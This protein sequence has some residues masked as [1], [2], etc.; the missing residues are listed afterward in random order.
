MQIRGRRV[1]PGEI[2]AVL[3][4]AAG[5]RQAAV[6]LLRDGGR[7]QLVA[8]V[9]LD[10]PD[11]FDPAVLL[12]HARERLPAHM[13]PSAVVALSRLPR[14]PSGK[15]DR[16]ELPRP[17]PSGGAQ[18]AGEGLEADLVAIFTDVLGLDSVGPEHDFF[19]LGGDS[20]LSIQAV[21]RAREVGLWITP[22]DI[23]EHRTAAALARAVAGRRA[24]IDAEQGPIEGELSLMPIHRWFLE[25]DPVGVD[26]FNQTVV[27]EVPA[28]LDPE[29]LR[30]AIGAL[31][32]HHDALRL[33]FG[34]DGGGWRAEHAPVQGD[35]VVFEGLDLGG[36][37]PDRAQALL[38]QAVHR[39]Q[40][41]LDLARGPLT[42]VLW[43]SAG[44]V[45]PGRLVWVVH[46][47]VV[48]GVSW[49]ILL[50]DLVRATLQLEAGEPIRLPPK[51]TAYRRWS[52]GLQQRA[53]SDPV[54]DQLGY[55]SQLGRGGLV[56][57]PR[58]LD[59]G[60]GNGC[61]ASEATWTGTLSPEQ[62]EALLTRAAAAYRTRTEELLLTAISQVVGAWAGGEVLIVA[63]GHGREELFDDVDL[64]RTVGWFTTV[65]PVRIGAVAGK[66]D[67]EAIQQ[68]KEAWRA[69]PERG[70]GFGLLLCFG[71]EQ[72][73][74]QLASLPPA[75][76]SFNHLG[77]FDG[78]ARS[79]RFRLVRQRLGAM[80]D[81]QARRPHALEITTLVID[82][83]LEVNL[84]Y[85][86]AVHRAET[87]AG[88]GDRLLERIRALVD[89]CLDPDAGG[90]TPS[91]VPLADLGQAQLDA[92]AA[93]FRKPQ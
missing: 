19:A 17:E 84:V 18:P 51:T 81:G 85:S 56:A 46:H 3:G 66:P 1:E 71:P 10:D 59:P 8:Y 9:A 90:L 80:T 23:F 29:W 67:R 20:I 25:H 11:R 42:A 64:S 26:R 68:T 57:L 22:R 75:V 31:V 58:D 7:E 88:V 87:I 43:A 83:R 50:E 27:L 63:E 13:V 89:H 62:T 28:D 40:G 47:F 79:D 45:R 44:P 21:A 69:I 82:G 49:R 41:G 4:E 5:V 36:L 52:E 73:R 48:D 37:P 14:T 61:A 6:V 12:A 15:L 77:R 60:G 38:D 30:R 93:R 32:E 72:A 70:L 54:L 24:R 2:E 86:T 74:S 35:H 34:R 55:W 53:G 76:A 78:G 92:L 16:S 33:R 65:F 91:D 39:L